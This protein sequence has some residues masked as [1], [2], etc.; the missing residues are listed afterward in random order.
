MGGGTIKDVSD[1]FL[2]F[3]VVFL[4]VL[5]AARLALAAFLGA[6]LA[7]AFLATFLGALLG[8]AFLAA[9]AR[10][11]AIKEKEKVRQLLWGIVSKCS[12]KS[13]SEFQSTRLN[14]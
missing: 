10:A 14:V 11:R 4:A 6:F 2:A 12:E 13:Q 3:L 5:G 1:H 7:G 9:V 8:A